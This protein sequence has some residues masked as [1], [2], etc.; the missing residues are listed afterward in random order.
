MSNPI[1]VGFHSNLQS[2]AINGK[3]L[4][5]TEGLRKPI[6]NP[7][8]KYLP[9]ALGPIGRGWQPRSNSRDKP[10]RNKAVA[11]QAPVKGQK[12]AP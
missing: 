4:P 12:T 3:P 7:K 9:M 2:K 10:R 11:G 8:G 1:G 5:N 6:K